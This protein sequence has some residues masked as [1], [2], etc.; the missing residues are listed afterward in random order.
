M[1]LTPDYTKT[2]E[3]DMEKVLAEAIIEACKKTLCFEQSIHIE[4]LIGITIDDAA[5]MLVSLKSKSYID[6]LETDF[7]KKNKELNDTLKNSKKNKK[8]EN[9]KGVGATIVQQDCTDSGMDDSMSIS[10]DDISE[11]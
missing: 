10:P 4:G 9:E 8:E 6:I 1:D 5:I 7:D 2:D 11:Q 3:V